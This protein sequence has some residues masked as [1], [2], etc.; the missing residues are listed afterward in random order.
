MMNLRTDEMAFLHSLTK[1]GT[2]ENKAIHSMC[3]M[4]ISKLNFTYYIFKNIVVRKLFNWSFLSYHLY[5]PVLPTKEIYE[6][7]FTTD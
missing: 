1:I 5:I 4:Y 3:F 6:Y 2:D 7:I